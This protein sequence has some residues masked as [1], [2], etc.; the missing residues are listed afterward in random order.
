M[1]KLLIIV[2]TFLLIGISVNAQSDLTSK[3][4]VKPSVLPMQIIKTDTAKQADKTGNPSQFSTTS[5]VAN[6]YDTKNQTIIQELYS[7]EDQR[8]SLEKNQSISSSERAS[9]IQELNS[10]YFVTKQKF[11]NYVSSKGIL[12][13]SNQEQSYYLSL[14]KGDGREQDYQEGINLISNSKK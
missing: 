12:N 10:N 9:K 13:I 14:L 6:N 4:G 8:Q 7:L 3:G 2:S 5:S 11:Y 1:N